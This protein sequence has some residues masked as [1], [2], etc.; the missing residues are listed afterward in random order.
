MEQQGMAT[1]PRCMALVGEQRKPFSPP[2]PDVDTLPKPPRLDMDCPSPGLVK[3]CW[4]Y[5]EKS[6]IPSSQGLAEIAQ[7]RGYNHMESDFFM[8]SLYLSYFP[9]KEVSAFRR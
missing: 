5:I 2:A 8:N 3:G 9:K 7:K 4:T 6:H 1:A